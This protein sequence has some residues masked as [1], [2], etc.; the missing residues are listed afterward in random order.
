MSKISFQICVEGNNLVVVSYPHPGGSP[1][2]RKSW[3]L[4][5]LGFRIKENVPIPSDIP[6]NKMEGSIKTSFE[7]VIIYS[8][9]QI[10]LTPINRQGNKINSYSMLYEFD[11]IGIRR[12]NNDK[13][14]SEKY[15]T[16][17]RDKPTLDKSQTWP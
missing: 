15:L 2:V 11:E 16:A 6:S 3:S 17:S 1:L 13:N 12:K 7:I 5:S 4:D 14:R 9:D 8:K 10:R